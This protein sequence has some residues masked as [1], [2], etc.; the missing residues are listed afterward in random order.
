MT[1]DDFY[2][3]KDRIRNQIDILI[4]G[5]N[6]DDN[7]DEAPIRFGEMIGKEKIELI[8]NLLRETAEISAEYGGF[9]G[10]FS[11][12]IDF[13]SDRERR[14]HYFCS[15]YLYFLDKQE[16]NPVKARERILKRRAE[17][18]KKLQNRKK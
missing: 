7:D 12:Y 6:I 5:V 13:L 1:F 11:A 2:T 3:K 4:L 18:I 9:N 8:L 17:M 10:Q 14:I 15:E 16:N